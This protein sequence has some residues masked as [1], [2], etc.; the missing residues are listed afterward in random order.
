MSWWIARAE[1][2]LT[3]DV[4]APPDQ[5]RDFYVDLDNL[6][7]VHP[8]IVS[9]EELSRSEDADGYRQSYRVVDQMRLG[10]VSFRIAYRARWRVPVA[11]AVESEARQS[12]SVRLRGR[13]TFAP[14]PTGTQITERLQIEAPRPLAA[15]TTHEAVKAHRVMLSRIRAHFATT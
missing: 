6:K 4:A 7:L 2:T 9:V 14:T 3:E 1:R 8:L 11:G 15:Y 10:P 5:V 13:V 12:P